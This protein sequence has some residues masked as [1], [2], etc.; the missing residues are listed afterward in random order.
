MDNIIGKKLEGRYLITELV[1]IGGMANVYKATDV[2]DGKTVAVK[3]L[4]EEFNGNEEFMRRFKNESKAIAVLSHP[5]IIKIYD[6]CFSSRVQCIVEEYIDGITLR[7]YMDEQ[8]A[9]SW[10][11]ALHFTVQ[12]LWALS[13]AHER[14]IVHRDIKPQNVMLLRDGTIKLTDFGIARFARSETY[15]LTDRAIGSVH[16]ISPEQAQGDSVDQRADIYSVGVMLYE[17]LT[18]RVPFDA[19][20]PVSVALKQIQLEAPAPRSIRADIPEALEEITM[21]AMKKNPDERYQSA[22]EMLRDI[23]EFKRNPSV[24]FEYDYLTN[25]EIEKRRYTKVVESV[26]RAD[27]KQPDRGHTGTITRRTTPPEKKPVRRAAQEKPARKQAPRQQRTDSA[28]RAER[29]DTRTYRGPGILTALFAITVAFV[30]ISAVFIGAMLYFNNPLEKVPDV[31]VPTLTGLRYDDVRTSAA[32]TD[33]TIEIDDT[34]YDEAERGSIISQKPKAGTKAK[35]GSTIRVVVSNG[36]KEVTMPYLIGYEETSAYAELVALDLDYERQEVYSS[37]PANTVVATSPAYGEEAVAG[38][39]VVVSVSIGPED[40][41]IAVP[42]VVGTEFTTATQLITDEGLIVG[43][44]TYQKS[45]EAAGIVISQTPEAGSILRTAE[46]VD[47]VISSGESGSDSGG[48]GPVR[49]TIPMPDTDE[50]SATLK[51]VFSG[52]IILTE[53]VDPS[54]IS[55][56]HPSFTGTGEVTIFILYNDFLYQTYEID[57][58]TGSYTLTEDNSAQHQ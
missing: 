7:E 34:K 13:H 4:R 22:A 43:S 32:Y 42:D 53:T 49:L 10:K 11:E 29:D 24:R 38:T 36:Q 51:A 2:T 15:T 48:G 39:K 30:I 26:K 44:V 46:S 12:V 18:G 55:Y 3:V 56:W 47:L 45:D 28:R 27:E 9:L 6:V 20:N 1:G 31:V 40:K 19:E 54:A 14:G 5:N 33:F 58:S 57:F 35:T 8:G 23:A 50:T 37:M 17:M 21:H 25:E 16:Y 41:E 52:D